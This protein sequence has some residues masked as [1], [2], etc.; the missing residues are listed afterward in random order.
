MTDQS[1]AIIS[2]LAR[3]I[4]LVAS[5][6]D[7]EALD[8]IRALASTGTTQ[9]TLPGIAAAAPSV[10]VDG[11]RKVMAMELFRY[12]Q[13]E[14]DHQTAKPTPERIT[15]V[16]ARL[17]EGYTAAEV[18]KA[19]DGAK[20]D[21]YEDGGKRYD[22]LELIC[23]NGTKLE[24]FITRGQK[25]TGA[26]V[27]EDVSVG[28]IEE[29]IGKLRRTMAGLRKDGRTTEYDAHARDLQVLMAKRELQPETLRG[30]R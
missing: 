23:R 21:A 24:D 28:G 30:A 25:H 26:I 19:I 27:V 4:G 7:A 15:K 29:Q 8:I 17:R 5:G 14:C 9:R 16:L 13:V 22:D 6:R 20:H 11:A 1:Q 12:W 2:E 10:N 3:A 18:R